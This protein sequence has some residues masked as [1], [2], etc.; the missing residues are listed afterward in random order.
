MRT[1]KVQTTQRILSV[2]LL[3]A[4]WKISNLN[5]LLAKFNF[6]ANLCSYGDWFECLYVGNLE[7]KF[8]QVEAHVDLMD[9]WVYI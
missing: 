2:S 9:K 3:F 8:C 4:F 7:D 6:P 1:A 5:L